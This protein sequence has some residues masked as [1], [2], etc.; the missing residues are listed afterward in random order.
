MNKL[1]TETSND[2]TNT[3]VLADYES[4]VAD[5]VS[6]KDRKW[7]EN[8]PHRTYRARPL[9]KDE[10]PI[11]LD[12]G[13]FPANITIV[14]KFSSH[15]RI[16]YPLAMYML[17][18]THGQLGVT[19]MDLPKREEEIRQLWEKYASEAEPLMRENLRGDNDD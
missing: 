16:R 17:S 10:F 19:P 9:I 14:K 8:R 11:L 1:T 6:E 12:A 18:P 5:H 15:C 7:F 13:P 4:T 2:G 3:Q